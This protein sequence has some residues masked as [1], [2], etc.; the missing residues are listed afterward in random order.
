MREAACRQRS[1]ALSTALD[2]VMRATGG[3]W[4]ARANG[5]ADRNGGDPRGCVAVPPGLRSY[6]LK[7]VSVPRDLEKRYYEGMGKQALWP[8]CHNVFQRPLFERENWLAYRQVNRMFA[9]AVAE[10]VRHEEAV[11]FIHDYHLAPLAAML[12][13]R[14]PN[15]STAHFWHV[16]WPGLATFGILPWR[17]E[18]LAELLDND[19]LGFQVPEHAANFA[20]AAAKFLGASCSGGRVSHVGCETEVQAFPIGVDVERIETLVRSPEVAKQAA[21]LR[22]E[23]NLGSCFVVVSVDR[24][25]SAKGIPERLRA[26]ELLL[27][28]RPEYRGRLVFVQVA[29]PSRT[30]LPGY[31]GEETQAAQVA[32]RIN[33]KYGRQGWQPIELLRETLAPDRVCALY[34]LADVC[35]VGSLHAGMSLTA[36]EFVASRVD[37]SGALVLSAFAGA[38]QELKEAIVINPFCVEEFADALAFALEMSPD[39]T[40]LRMRRLRERVAQ[41]NIYDWVGSILETLCEVADKRQRQKPPIA[42]Q[43]EQ[44][45]G[46]Q[47][48][49]AHGPALVRSA[50]A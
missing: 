13:E 2:A 39:E 14:C 36:K 11:I 19:L 26:V 35:V 44:L 18:L 48:L 8:L 29:A 5:E 12:R 21:A 34:R 20:S 31:Q 49:S 27:D 17:N 40:Q 32:A 6:T 45:A 25:D 42:G 9:D 10:E 4:V 43:A 22:G 24:F 41:N 47:H 15:I 30:T 28:T 38:A 16:P 7:R 3:L 23:L 37:G 33:R 50:G 1:G 46:S